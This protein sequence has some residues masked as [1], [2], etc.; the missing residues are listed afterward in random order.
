MRVGGWH[1]SHFIIASAILHG[2][3]LVV[4]ALH[5]GWWPWLLGL[6]ILNHIVITV[7]GLLPRSALLGPNLVRLDAAS[8]TRGE[9]AITIDDGPDP[10]V[11]PA[12]LAILAQHGAH[13]SFF[14]IG[15]RA[16]EHPALV[17][18]IVAAGHRVENHGQHHFNHASLCGPAGWR[19]EVGDAQRTLTAIAGRPPVYFRALA[20]LRNPFLEPVLQSLGLHLTSWTRRGYDTRC[21][22]ATL[23]FSRLTHNLASG[24]ILL[25][26]DG[27]AARTATGEPVV[28]AVLPRLLEHL[29]QHGLHAVVLPDRPA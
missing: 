23:V 25:L 21:G 24:D 16:A 18:D 13:A 22:D 28:L 7:A 4:L 3:L 1:P 9:V 5:P 15:V 17:A 14:C 10:Q 2:I 29:A 19:R 12:I 20:G 11:T 27:H 26:H 6:C 8:A